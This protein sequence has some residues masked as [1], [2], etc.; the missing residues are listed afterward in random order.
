MSSYRNMDHSIIA[1]F[2]PAF[3]IDC[4]V[5]VQ[6][7]EHRKLE[8]ELEENWGSGQ[9]RSWHG[10]TSR[11]KNRSRIWIILTVEEPC[12][13]RERTGNGIGNWDIDKDDMD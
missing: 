3:E 12:R 9:S 1:A 2:S 4:Y 6:G 13:K 11:P 7:T 5:H 10:L 8:T